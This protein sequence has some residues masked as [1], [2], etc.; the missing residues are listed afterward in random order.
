MLFLLTILIV[1]FLLIVGYFSLGSTKSAQD[2][3]WGV[4]FSQKHAK[5]LKLD[6]RETYLALLDDLKVKKVKIASY[7]DLI[8][9]QE[10][11]YDFTDLDWQIAEAGN[12]GAEVLLAVGMKSPRWPECHIPGWAEKIGKDSQ[13]ERIIKF[14][15]EIVLRYRDSNV[16][17]GWQVENEPFFVFGECS[18]VDKE[19]LKKEVDLIKSLDLKH[20]P[21]VIAES[22]EGFFW[23]KAAEFGDIVGI[24][25]Y[26]KVWLSQFKHYLTYPFTPVVYRRKAE[27]VKKLTGK[28]VICVELQAEPW[29]P[30]LL[31]DLPLAEQQKTMNLKQFR[32]NIDF[33]SKTGLEEFYLWGAEWWYWLKEKQNK[34]EI[35]NEARILFRP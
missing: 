12:Y 10:N 9:P 2:I 15:K 14:L 20:R 35:W 3:G 6:W 27:L 1:I 19:F 33:A 11:N 23:L 32:Y 8:E 4:V 30:K 16:I 25:M 17:K 5:Y 29:G 31:Y 26:K 24:T 7:W 34:P 13:Q 18:W 28:E 21:I 22:G